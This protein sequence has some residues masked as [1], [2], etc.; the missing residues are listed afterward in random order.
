MIPCLQNTPKLSGNVAQPG[1][2][3]QRVRWDRPVSGPVVVN[4]GGQAITD[5]ALRPETNARFGVPPRY[6]A[7]PALHR[8]LVSVVVVTH[9]V[10][11]QS[12]RL[13]SRG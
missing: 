11:H 8:P 9:L 2:H 12:G 7:W 6:S 13:R 10:T 1:L 3:S 4:D 5:L